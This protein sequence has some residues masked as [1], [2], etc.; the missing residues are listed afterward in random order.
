MFTG[1]ITHLGK[2]KSNKNGVLEI[3]TP[4]DFAKKLVIGTS[5]SVNGICLTA[6][7]KNKTGFTIQ[8]MR[9]TADKT[10]IGDLQKGEEVN[11]E[12]CATANTLLAGHIVAGHIDARSTIKKITTEKN[13]WLF[14]FSAPKNIL[15]YIVNKGSIAINGISLTVIEAKGNTFTIGIIPHTFEKTMLHNAKKGDV[16]NLEVDVFA[17]YIE[18]L[19]KN[20]HA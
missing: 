16:V 10:N 20:R 15:K 7:T 2:V 18:K 19:I 4:A 3:T 13:S 14:E 6:I 11:L 8:Y 17:K 12:L 1:I 5:I 9:E